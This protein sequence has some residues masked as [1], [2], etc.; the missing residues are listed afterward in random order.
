MQMGQRKVIGRVEQYFTDAR[1]IIAL[2]ETFPDAHYVQAHLHPRS[3]L[4]C[5]MSGLAMASTSQERGW[6]PAGVRCGS[7]QACG[8]S[9]EWKA[10]WRCRVSISTQAGFQICR[11]VAG[12]WPSLHSCVA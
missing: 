2:C 6:C 4:F 3:Q 5:P 11:I 12:W 7:Q 1:P 10:W 8:M 9:Y